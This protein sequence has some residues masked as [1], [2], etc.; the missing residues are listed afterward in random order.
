MNCIQKG[1]SIMKEYSI[2]LMNLKDLIQFQ[3]LVFANDLHGEIRQ[4]DYACNVRF[5]LGLSMALPLDAATLSLK[6]CTE[7]KEADIMRI[8]HATV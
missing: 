2:K 6:D 4:K 8:C 3:K 5:G 7:A 1:C